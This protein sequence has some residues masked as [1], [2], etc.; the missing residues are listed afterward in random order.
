MPVPGD[1]QLNF[2]AQQG[3]LRSVTDVRAVCPHCRNATTFN[4]K[5]MVSRYVPPRGME[6]RLIIECNFS[7]CGGH[8][9]V[10]TV[11][12]PGGT[13]LRPTDPF[14]MHPTRSV[15]PRHPSIPAPIA[16]DWEEGQ[17]VLEAGA[18]KA[19]AV[20]FRRVLYGA[21]N[22]K[23]CTLQPF[24]KGLKELITKYRLPMIFD[25]WLPAIRDDGHDGAHPDRAL[26]VPAENILETR[27]YTSELL[28]YLYI[29]PYEFKE[30]QKRIAAGDLNTSVS[31][32][33]SSTSP[34]VP[35]AS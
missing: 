30:R 12:A 25:E 21:L 17:T 31:T 18:M 24:H 10:E 33:A 35:S 27:N 15:E 11:T 22:E 7:K 23:G 3:Q 6:I 2:A 34:N 4:V 16:D 5:A 20:M 29:E 28:R 32:E 26:D 19:A 8:S 9:F 13:R 1:F 14:F